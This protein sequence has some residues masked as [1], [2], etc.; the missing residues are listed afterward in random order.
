MWNRKGACQHVLKWRW[1]GNI[2]FLLIFL[3]FQEGGNH[4]H[5]TPAHRFAVWRCWCS[6][7]TS[8]RCHLQREAELISLFNTFH[9]LRHPWT[10]KPNIQQVELNLVVF[11]VGGC[12]CNVS[13]VTT[14]ASF[15]PTMWGL[16][17]TGG[18]SFERAWVKGSKS[19]C[20]ELDIVSMA[21]LIVYLWIAASVV[22][23]NKDMFPQHLELPSGL[24]IFGHQAVFSAVPAGDAGQLA[25]SKRP[26]WRIWTEGER[27]E[28]AD[29]QLRYAAKI[30]GAEIRRVTR[31]SW[32][33]LNTQLGWT[34]LCWTIHG[35]HEYFQGS[36]SIEGSPRKEVP[37]FAA[38]TW[39][40]VDV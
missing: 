6:R 21:S 14:T 5:A 22:K 38:N 4:P 28:G 33:D 12:P 18:S 27:A 37:S 11:F 34:R 40:S 39:N 26:S 20:V 32:D 36:I 24:G 31:W 10:V 9:C 19:N 16:A 23:T 8:W 7:S 1:S 25:R 29:A 3:I 17:V 13:S 15:G 35:D 2:S 30:A